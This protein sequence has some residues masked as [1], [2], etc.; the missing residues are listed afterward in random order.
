MINS[1]DYKIDEALNAIEDAVNSLTTKRGVVLFSGG[2]DSVVLKHIID[3]SCYSNKFVY[4]NVRTTLESSNLI[5]FLY[6]F[7][8]VEK[9]EPKM[10]V[11]ELIR[12]VGY[13]PSPSSKFCCK[14][15]YQDTMSKAV[16]DT[17]IV[18]WG[19]RL[20]EKGRTLAQCNKE[21]NGK[22]FVSPLLNFTEEDICNYI[23]YN[24]IEVCKDYTLYGKCLNCAICVKRS[25]E[26]KMQCIDKYIDI[27]SELKLACF[28]VWSSNPILQSKFVSADDYWRWWLD[29][30]W[31]AYYEKYV[32][33]KQV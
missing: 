28:D 8:D 7:D 2:R 9:I 18:L 13:M 12:H 19:K 20:N 21:F 32:R 15:V 11:Y 10:S 4:R 6:S 17:N 31:R 30:D 24:N 29:I 33:G 23:E 27:A 22:M 25:K 16:E 5:D 3:N 14:V 26:I 1:L